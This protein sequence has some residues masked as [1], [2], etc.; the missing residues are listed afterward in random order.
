[1]SFK[2][3]QE[4]I[5]LNMLLNGDRRDAGGRY[6]GPGR[7]SKKNKHIVTVMGTHI[8]VDLDKIVDAQEY[9]DKKNKTLKD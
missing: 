9:W 6:V 7:G 3:G 5:I 4:V 8:H 2:E 1:M